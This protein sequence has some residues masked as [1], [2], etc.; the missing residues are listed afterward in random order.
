MARTY[1][2]S[3][4]TRRKT[5]TAPLDTNGSGSFEEQDRRGEGGQLGD[6]AERRENLTTVR[7]EPDSDSRENRDDS[8]EYGRES[9]GGREFG[10]R[11]DERKARD[12]DAEQGSRHEQPPN[13]RAWTRSRPCSRPGSRSSRP[14]RS[15]RKPW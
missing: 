15:W 7:D 12:G 3:T 5:A 9:R 14:G 10:E 13:S 6:N 11:R 8:R 1:Q 4:A 2:P